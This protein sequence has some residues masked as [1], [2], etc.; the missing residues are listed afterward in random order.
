[1]RRQPQITGNIGLYYVCYRLSCMG[2][3]AMPTSRN[4]RGIDIIAYN[5]NCSKMLAIQV[6]SLSSRNAVPL[7]KNLDN[8]MGDF[9]IIIRDVYENPK[10]FIL[11]PDEVKKLAGISGEDENIS[12][13]L[14]A[15]NYEKEEFIEAWD[16]I[17]K[18]Y[19]QN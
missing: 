2:W 1:M 13:W 12:Y 5:Y 6:K 15:D 9:C 17:G 4:A 18:G 3:N 14:E 11:S 7:G 10:T 16:R 8:I 19:E